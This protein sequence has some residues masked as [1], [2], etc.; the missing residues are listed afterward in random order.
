MLGHG[1]AL[2]LYPD[3][4]VEARGRDLVF[5][6]DRRLGSATTTLLNQGDIAGEVCSAARS[7]EDDDRA[8]IAVRRL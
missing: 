4:I 2:L 1:D 8:A 3:G 6:V 5:G 7:G